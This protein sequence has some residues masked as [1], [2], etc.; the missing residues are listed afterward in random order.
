[1]IRIIKFL[2]PIVILASCKKHNFQIENL[3]GNKISVIGHGGMGINSAYPSNSLE[4]ILKCI[5]S[6][7]NG[8][9]IDI[10][11][12]SDGVFLAFHDDFLENST[13]GSGSIYNQAWG[14]TA[15]TDLRSSCRT[16]QSQPWVSKTWTIRQK[17]GK[18]P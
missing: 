2:I 1:M 8:V 16:K 7:A 18:E 14:Q 10:Q 17:A 11:M 3:N 6:G 15:G 12:T 9:E 4:S 13:D 5:D